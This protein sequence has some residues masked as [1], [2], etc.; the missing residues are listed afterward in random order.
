[1]VRGRPRSMARLPAAIK[2]CAR[3]SPRGAC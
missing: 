1:M 3:R 2:P